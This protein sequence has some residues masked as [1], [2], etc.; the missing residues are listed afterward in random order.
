MRR[1][2][3]FNLVL[4]VLAF[5]I[6]GTKASGRTT[7][8][9]GEGRVIPLDWLRRH[10]SVLTPEADRRPADQTFLTYPEWFLVHSP[11]EQ[12]DYFEANTSTTFPFMTHVDQLW[13]SYETVSKEI[14]GQFEYNDQYHTMIRVIATSTTVE[15]AAKAGYE[16]ILGRLTEAVSGEAGTDED[17]FNHRFAKDYV[18]FL[19]EAP[20]YE[21]DFT[22]RL[23]DLWIQTP[24]LGAN[25][26]RKLERRYFLTSEL[27]VKAAY[28]QLIKMGVG[29][30]VVRNTVVVVDRLPEA[31]AD[32]PLI[33]LME[34]LQ[35]GTAVLRLPR[36][37]PFNPTAVKLANAGVAFKEIAGNDSAILV[38]VLTDLAY[39]FQLV[40]CQ[41][42]FTQPI[43][44][45][46]DQKRIAFVTPV[47][48]LGGVLK[49]LSDQQITIEHVYD[50]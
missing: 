50:Y 28:G 48:T 20:F 15:Y 33:E 3:I 14:E 16:L 29:D 22:S 12:A 4:A 40:D 2:T 30:D 49:A 27:L 31:L 38:T 46:D 19:G 18:D 35:D 21:F 13:E 24:V 26:L 39:D 9:A 43:T 6:H 36:Y 7:V 34:T 45:K 5:G 25:L 8:A 47:P 11:R 23:F 41:V 32:D 10:D 37:A 17:R 1:L 42:L 44:S